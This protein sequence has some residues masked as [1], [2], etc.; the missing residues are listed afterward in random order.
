MAAQVQHAKT[1]RRPLEEPSSNANF[2]S[3]PETTTAII[4]ADDYH[5][6]PGFTPELAQVGTL[7]IILRAILQAQGINATRIIVAL[8]GLARNVIR[9]E[10]LRTGRLPERVEWFEIGEH[11]Q[12]PQL[13]RQVAADSARIVLVSACAAYHPCLFEMIRDS[14]GRGGVTALTTDGQFVGIAALSHGAALE[15]ASKCPPFV[16]TPR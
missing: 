6:K 5:D 13:V 1:V 8:S 12:L 9:R 2:A 4:F 10:L 15:I 7:P 11:G 3:S 14:A 16:E